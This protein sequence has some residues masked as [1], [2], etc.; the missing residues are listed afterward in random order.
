MGQPFLSVCCPTFKRHDF[1]QEFLW[2]FNRQDYPKDRHELIVLDDAGQYRPKIEGNVKVVSTN[3]RWRT[4]GEKRNAF[5]Q[6]LDDRSEWLVIADDDDLYQPHW[7]STI[8]KAAPNA[9]W[10]MPRVFVDVMWRRKPTFRIAL[11]HG[12]YHAACAFRR[13]MFEKIRGY[14]KMQRQEDCNIFD[15]MECMRNELRKCVL[16]FRE[17]PYLIRRSGRWR[18]TYTATWMTGE[19]YN[20]L[21]KMEVEKNVDL[22]ERSPEKTLQ[23]I[24]SEFNPQHESDLFRVTFS[25]T[26]CTPVLVDDFGFGRPDLPASLPRSEFSFFGAHAPSRI[27]VEFKKPVEVVGFMNGSSKSDPI[28]PCVFKIN[29][30]PI[31]YA[32]YPRERTDSANL[33]PGHYNLD[34]SSLEADWKHTGWAFREINE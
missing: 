2:C 5:L 17:A 22:V 10:I 21:S 27:T 30:T 16:D 18:G 23:E 33:P 13:T 8:A 24:V 14:A 19:G 12:Y 4:L 28:C 25:V 34:V 9:D 31:G 7:L 3:T 6:L 26:G 29:G 1:L 15:R 11:T 20:R 32:F